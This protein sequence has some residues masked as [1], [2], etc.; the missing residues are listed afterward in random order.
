[1]S[2]R[3]SNG[4]EAPLCGA[5]INGGGSY[6]VCVVGGSVDISY[7]APFQVGLAE[8]FRTRSGVK[9]LGATVASEIDKL[10]HGVSA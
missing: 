8:T 5:R 4:G 9:S 7:L 10:Y 2:V 6:V 3:H 1:L